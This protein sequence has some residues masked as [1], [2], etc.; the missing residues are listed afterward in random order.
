MACIPHDIFFDLST[1]VT[2]D[3]G[4]AWHTL[5]AFLRGNVWFVFLEPMPRHAPP[6]K[7]DP[8]SS[9]V[10]KW[11]LNL[12][13]LDQSML[14]SF[15]ILVVASPLLAPKVCGVKFVSFQHLRYTVYEFS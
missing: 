4:N 15:F 3:K 1:S 13:R 14:S 7:V 12:D 6:Q 11:F 10:K 5:L 9:C 2:Y 8:L